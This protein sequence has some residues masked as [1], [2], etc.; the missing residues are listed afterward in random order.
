M[1]GA[2]GA[3]ENGG[4]CLREKRHGF[5]QSRSVGRSGIRQ[6]RDDMGIAAFFLRFLQPPSRPPYDGMPPVQPKCKQFEAADPVIAA[7]QVR[8]LVS[9]KRVLLLRSELV[10]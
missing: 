2:A 1:P 5:N 8:Q 9:Q 3:D 10:P 4:A 7:A 6:D